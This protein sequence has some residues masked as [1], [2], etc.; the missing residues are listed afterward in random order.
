MCV[1]YRRLGVRAK[2]QDLLGSREE[3][4]NDGDWEIARGIEVWEFW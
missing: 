4:R 3:D 2:V 1:V